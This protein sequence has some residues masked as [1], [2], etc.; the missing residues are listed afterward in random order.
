[1]ARP[2]TQSHERPLRRS[3]LRAIATMAI[4]LAVLV[5]LFL[6]FGYRFFMRYEGY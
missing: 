4:V 5:G 2:P 3:G 6:Y 1:M